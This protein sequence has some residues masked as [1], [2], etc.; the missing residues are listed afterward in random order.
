MSMSESH[1]TAPHD[2]TKAAV[3]LL[4]MGTPV[5]GNHD[6]QKEIPEWFVLRDRRSQG[7]GGH[8]WGP[9]QFSGVS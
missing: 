3:H 5:I 2:M 7:G 9:D 8:R 6:M 1:K 4:C